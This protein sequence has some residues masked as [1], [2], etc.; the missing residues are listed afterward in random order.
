MKQKN[1]NLT[2]IGFIFM[3]I[4]FSPYIALRAGPGFLYIIPFLIPIIVIL[5]IFHY[6]DRV[7]QNDSSFLIEIKKDLPDMSPIHILFFFLLSFPLWLVLGLLKVELIY[8][9]GFAYILY[10]IIYYHNKEE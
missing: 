3:I 2:P 5:L 4:A 9:V 6:I 7:K 8:G 10:T 1:S